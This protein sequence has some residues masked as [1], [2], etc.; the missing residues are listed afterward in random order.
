MPK[1]IENVDLNKN[2]LQN[3]VIQP[4]ASAPS[5]PKVGQIYY[6]TTDNNLYR[7]NGTSWV[8]YQE[9]LTTASAGTLGIDST[10]TASSSN[11]VTSGGVKDYVDSN[12]SPPELFWVTLT[13]ANDTITGNKTYSDIS[14]AASAGKLCCLIEGVSYYYL[15]V[16]TESYARFIKIGRSSSD[17]SVAY[18]SI[19]TSDVWSSG[20]INV[21]QKITAS[22]ILKG[23]GSGGVTAA[24]AGTDYQAV[25]TNPVTGTGTSGY[26][27]KFNGT[28][29]VTS[30]PQLGSSTTTYLTN[31][32]T[33]T[34]PVGTNGHSHGD[35]TSAGD[36]TATATIASG[37]RIIINDESASK[38]TNS[39]IT[40]GTTTTT[41]LSNAGTWLTPAKG[42][43]AT[44]KTASLAVASWNT[45]NK[46][47]SVTVSGVTAS[48]LVE[49][50][51]APA[52]WAVASAAGVYC[53][54]QAANSL[55]FT[56]S[57]IPT[58]AI[59]VN[60]VIWG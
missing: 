56:C 30:G 11:L 27:A 44:T 58:A 4:L 16:I 28:S 34:T 20:I 7:Y 13:V 39:S 47:I 10:P 3:V 23:D 19:N 8:S 18:Y 51:P 24:A 55:T 41:F 46:T 40:F 26:L 29:T 5:S 32:G 37:D 38:I 33:W 35:I 15:S 49:V 50:S 14:T 21:Q 25:L 45:T 48:N 17:Y 43:T 52:S 9:E 1:F 6:N 42:N 2:Q 12:A 57:S 31:A 54:A 60:V 53:S 22:G 36:I 59:T